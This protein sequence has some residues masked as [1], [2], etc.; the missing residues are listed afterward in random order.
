MVDHNLPLN[1][2]IA[3]V[4]YV[5]GYLL[6]ASG[7]HKSTETEVRKVNHGSEKKAAYKFLVHAFLTQACV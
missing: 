4:D 6:R 3:L 2:Q 7:K 1:A 5:H